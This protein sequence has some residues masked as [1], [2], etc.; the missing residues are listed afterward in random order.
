MNKKQ[1]N[2]FLDLDGVFAD[3]EKKLCEIY[4][5]EINQFTKKDWDSALKI[6]TQPESNI[7]L[8]LDLDLL[9][10]AL[11]FYNLMLELRKKE[12]IEIY[13]LTSISLNK[14][15]GRRVKAEKEL[16]VIKNL[17][18]E[19]PILFSDSWKLK[20]SQLY[21]YNILSKISKTEYINILI[22]DFILQKENWENSGGIFIH[23][24]NDFKQSYNK[25]INIIQNGN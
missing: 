16:W 19:I 4:N 8:F 7:N 23:H 5:K 17:G 22:D 9:P 3:L 12:N 20:R 1:Y 14:T 11:D 13:F 15:F 6:Y 10:G 21:F 25:L 2:I 24:E 18:K